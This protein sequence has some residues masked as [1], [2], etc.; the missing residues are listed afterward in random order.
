[1]QRGSVMVATLSFS[2]LVLLFLMVRLSI[3]LVAPWVVGASF[4]ALEGWVFLGVV[5]SA[6]CALAVMGFG[7]GLRLQGRLCGGVSLGYMVD[8]CMELT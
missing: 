6:S 4:W 2:R 3:A 8:F 1:V 5:C 7:S